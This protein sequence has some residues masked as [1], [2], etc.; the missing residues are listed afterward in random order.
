ML[1]EMLDKFAAQAERNLR[2]KEST[3]KSELKMMCVADL[4][5][6]IFFVPDYQCVYRWTKNEVQNLLDGQ[7]RLTTIF[8]ILKYRENLVN[9]KKLEL[10]SI[11]YET[12][13]KSEEYLKI[14]RK[15]NA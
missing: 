12:R 9:Y 2:D 14:L 8:L 5:G 10:Y 7:Q 15:K 6:K 13:P 11:K 4:L 1:T 3:A